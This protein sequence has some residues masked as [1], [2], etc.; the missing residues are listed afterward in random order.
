MRIKVLLFLFFATM[1]TSLWA[2]NIYILFLFSLS[3][4]LLLPNHKWW[5]DI[6][7]SLLFFS[8]F[9]CLI[10]YMNN[11]IGSGFVFISTLIIPISFYRFGRWIIEWIDDE[12]KRLWFIFLSFLCFLLPVLFLT[13]QDMI[14]VGFI[15]ESRTMLSDIGKE[16]NT[17]A[18]TLYGLMS[19]T[20]I[21]FISLFFAKSLN[22][23]YKIIYL[24]VFAISILIV[25]HL[26]NRTGLF[27]LLI[28]ILFSTIYSTKKN[29]LKIIPVM[30]FLFV[31]IFFMIEF[32]VIDQ[33]ILDAYAQ[34]ETSTTANIAEFGGRSDR[35]SDAISNLFTNLFGWKRKSYAHNLWLDLAAVGGWLALFPFLIASF[36][37]FVNVK[38]VIKKQVTP[39]RLV[40]LSTFLSMFFNSMV[41]PVIEGSLL[42]FG[43][44]LMIW[45]M[46]KSVTFES[47]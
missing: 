25:L 27:L 43:L 28:C 35:W 33:D 36:K 21:G 22:Y 44:F 24:T 31:I 40:L 10:Q 37:T 23:K 20:G 42:F 38:K 7:L 41:E 29:P 11:G 14:L 6:C 16:D 9:Y 8:L 17:L 19:S 4:W 46:L 45:G 1:L 5:D 18:A 15:N 12:R 47:R 30:L 3:T 39:F 13:I 26:V 34:R 32:G 2:N